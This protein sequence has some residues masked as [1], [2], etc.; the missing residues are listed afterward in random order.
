MAK[1]SIKKSDIYYS[2]NNMME[3][4]D[5]NNYFKAQ[6]NETNNIVGFEKVKKHTGGKPNGKRK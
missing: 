1:K 4:I 3:C 5:W 6:A 2:F